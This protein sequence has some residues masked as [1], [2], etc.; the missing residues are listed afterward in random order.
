[1]A[2][3]SGKGPSIS[4]SEVAKTLA[5]RR[6]VEFA[7]ECGFR[8]MVVERDNQLVTFALEMKKNLSSWVGHIIQDVLC[9]L[10]GFKW[11]QVQFTKRSANT[12]AH[13][14]ARY[15]KQVHMMLSGW[16]NPLHL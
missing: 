14:L 11:S 7:L 13:L 2:T 1:M 10:N 5:C 3:L 12:V 15:A 4:C 8:E 6:A 9:M 16:R